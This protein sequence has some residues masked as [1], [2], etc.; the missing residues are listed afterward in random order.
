MFFFFVQGCLHVWS[1]NLAVVTLC[2]C[3]ILNGI[4][5]SGFTR[6]KIE[7][8]NDF[9]LESLFVDGLCCFWVIL[10]SGS[11]GFCVRGVWI[12]IIKV[13]IVLCF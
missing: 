4:Y 2:L 13:I 11:S 6:R 10:L 5:N 9:A 7:K 1:W 3:L 12:I 8:V